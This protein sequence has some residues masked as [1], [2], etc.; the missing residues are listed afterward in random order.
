MNAEFKARYPAFIWPSVPRQKEVAEPAH[1]AAASRT[2]RAAAIVAPGPDGGL[3]SEFARL[4]W[5]RIAVTL[6]AQPATARGPMTPAGGD[7]TRTVPYRGSLRR[8]ARELG[9]LGVRAVVAGSPA[10]LALADRLAD[11]LDLPGND[12]AS[13]AARGDLG[14][15][16]Q[17]LTAHGLTALRLLRTTSR[18]RA[19]QWAAFTALPAYVVTT[20]ATTDN[21]PELVCRSPKEIAEAWHT[22][23]A[24]QPGP[25][26]PM[27]IRE[28]VEGHRYLVN[29]LSGRDADGHVTHT[30]TDTWSCHHSPAHAVER[31]DLVPQHGRMGRLLALYIRRV[32]EALQV[33]TGAT[34]CE[35]AYLPGRGPLLLSA[36]AFADQAEAALAARLALGRDTHR[37]AAHCAIH[38]QS[39]TSVRAHGALHLLRVP[40]HPDRD[41]RLDRWMLR[42]IRQ[43]PTVLHADSTLLPDAPVRAHVPP[44][45]L[46]LR[47]GDPR[48]VEADYRSIRA[49]E[50]LGLYGGDAS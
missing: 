40:L 22:L 11:A 49:H 10:G 30:V 25:P 33:S 23:Q 6:D 50:R 44:G 16:N 1:R 39:R 4:G 46:V 43:L 9:E 47:S 12:P 7:F 21:A 29:T 2:P 42:T 27:V 48:A 14:A 45:E 17:A 5:S 38:D 24:Q 8:T 32:L 26:V 36:R 28:H 18:T 35:L 19:T 41:G 34:A 15:Q 37:D 13:T 31:L 3:P 20:A